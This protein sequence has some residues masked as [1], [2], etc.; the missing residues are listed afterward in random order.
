MLQEQLQLYINPGV[1]ILSSSSSCVSASHRVWNTNSTIFYK[2]SPKVSNRGG[3]K[4]QIFLWREIYSS[5]KI[6]NEMHM[7]FVCKCLV[8]GFAGCINK[9]GRERIVITGSSRRKDQTSNILI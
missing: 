8:N 7:A 6:W 9:L 1:I 5:L 2:L 3:N 4:V